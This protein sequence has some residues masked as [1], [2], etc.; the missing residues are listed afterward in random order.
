MKATILSKNKIELKVE[1]SY[2]LHVPKSLT[3]LKKVYITAIIKN[4]NSEDIRDT[5]I[6]LRFYNRRLKSYLHYVFEYYHLQM[7]NDG[8]F[9]R[10]SNN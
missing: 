3:E 2:Y 9:G 5:L 7:Y 10:K 6:L 8:S 4:P 1:C